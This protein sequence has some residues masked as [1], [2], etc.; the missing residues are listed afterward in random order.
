ME[1]LISLFS[2][3]IFVL[4]SHPCTH[5]RREKSEAWFVLVEFT[6]KVFLFIFIFYFF[7]GK[8]NMNLYMLLELYVIL[9]LG[10]AGEN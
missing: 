1:L 5:K 8:L 9:F 2:I 4:A 7:M 6:L 3:M 10:T